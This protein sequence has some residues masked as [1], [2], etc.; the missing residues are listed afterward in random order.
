MN[1]KIFGD[2]QFS[3]LIDVFISLASTADQS[4]GVPRFP[5]YL[6]SKFYSTETTISKELKFSTTL[7]DLGENCEICFVSIEGG[8]IV[9]EVVELI[10]DNNKFKMEIG[11]AIKCPAKTCRVNLVGTKGKKVTISIRQKSKLGSYIPDDFR[12]LCQTAEK[13]WTPMSD[14]ALLRAIN[15]SSPIPEFPG[16]DPSLVRIRG[17]LLTNVRMLSSRYHITAFTSSASYS[18]EEINTLVQEKVRK[19][20]YVYPPTPVYL[21][22]DR[23]SSAWFYESGRGRTLIRQLD[24]MLKQSRIPLL[25]IAYFTKEWTVEFVGEGSIDAGGPRREAF[26]DLCDEI[27][28]RDN[29]FVES[30]ASREKH[31]G[32]KIPYTKAFFNDLKCAGALVAATMPLNN[33]RPFHFEPFVWKVI[34]GMSITEQDM[35]EIDPELH[36]IV[37]GIR[38]GMTGEVTHKSISGRVLDKFILTDKTPQAKR[39]KILS[40]IINQRISEMEKAIAP[41]AS[42][43]HSII[44]LSITSTI[45]FQLL[46]EIVCAEEELSVSQLLGY[47]SISAYPIAQK[48]FIDAINLLT[49]TQRR[50]LVKFTTGSTALP[51][52]TRIRVSIAWVDDPSKMNMRNGPL[53]HASTCFMTLS[54]PMYSS[55]EVM[56]AKII[57]A[58]EFSTFITDLDMDFKAFEMRE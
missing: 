12:K 44:P 43:F 37:E 57:T 27:I 51:T 4:M 49:P 34:T 29:I 15:K 54:M 36:D 41:F 52:N 33:R 6:Y 11:K 25:Q 31:E 9:N 2:P 32:R 21:K 55:V 7:K 45:P 18:L 26:D 50:K 48:M 14:I 22:L 42:G 47:M 46:E 13:V 19:F 39:D 40:T 28:I 24:R 58:M 17:T 8:N 1:Q 10:I 23:F 16:V 53:P 3:S 20:L 5:L 56:A 38:N 35:T 30:P